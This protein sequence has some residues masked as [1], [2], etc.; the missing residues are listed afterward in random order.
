[1]ILCLTPNPAIDRTLYVDELQIGAVHRAKKVLTAAGGKGL[2]VAR[3]IRMLGGNPLC[4]GPLG[5]NAGNL[6]AELAEREGFSSHWTLVKNETRTCVILVQA[7]RDATVINEP[8]AEIDLDECNTLIADVWGQALSASLV[9]VSGSL[10]PGFQLNQFESMLAG[11]VA[12]GKSVWVDTS[13]GAL[14]TALGVRGICVKVNGDELGDALGM[15]ISS[16]EQAVKAI[17]RLREGGISQIAVTFGRDGAVMSSDNGVWFAQPPQIELVSSV[18]SGDAFLGG[19]AFALDAGHSPELALR[20]AVA[21]GAANAL[22]FGGGIFS[23]LDFDE[24]SPKVQISAM[25]K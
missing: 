20:H 17:A 24:I 8:G 2:N 16:A 12:R 4:M 11:L 13:G 18:G 14:K 22:E 7:N 15:E 21:A 9:C 3:T 5:G 19:L 6:L 10:P 25:V 23:L 1:M